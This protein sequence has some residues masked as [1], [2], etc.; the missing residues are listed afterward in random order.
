M[1][2]APPLSNLPPVV[3]IDS[4]DRSD[5]CEPLWVFARVNDLVCLLLSRVA[6]VSSLGQFGGRLACLVSWGISGCHRSDRCGSPV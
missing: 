5:R 6:A 2:K 1:T 4:L 3:D